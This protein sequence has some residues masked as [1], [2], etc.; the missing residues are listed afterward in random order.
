MVLSLDEWRRARKMSRKEVA[1][2]LGISEMTMS[3]WEQN[4]SKIPIGAAYALADLYGIYITEINFFPE[5][6]TKCVEKG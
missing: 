6:A 1:E 2:K 5:N 4:P 3:R